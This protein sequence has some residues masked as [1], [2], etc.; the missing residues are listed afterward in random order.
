[1][2][3]I[4]KNLNICAP[5]MNEN[6]RKKEIRTQGFQQIFPTCSVGKVLLNRRVVSPFHRPL[7]LWHWQLGGGG[8]PSS[9]RWLS[10]DSRQFSC[11][12]SISI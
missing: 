4:N 8:V 3:E 10:S 5:L 2:N 12:V 6:D 9:I 7:A 1:M 11:H